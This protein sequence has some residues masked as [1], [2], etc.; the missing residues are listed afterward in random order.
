MSCGRALFAP[1]FVIIGAATSSCTKEYTPVLRRLD[2][3]LSIETRLGRKIFDVTPAKTGVQA[4]SGSNPGETT[5][6]RFF[7]NFSPC[8]LSIVIVLT[9]SPI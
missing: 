5:P 3:A 2:F 4:P 1:N 7:H 8:T 6:G 9:R